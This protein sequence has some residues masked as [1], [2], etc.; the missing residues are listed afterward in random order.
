M[1]C[2]TFFRNS[3]ACACYWLV[4]IMQKKI[5]SNV[6]MAQIY[7]STSSISII[8][9]SLVK[10][11]IVKFKTKLASTT[12]TTT[13]VWICFSEVLILISFVDWL[14]YEIVFCLEMVLT[15]FLWLLLTTSCF[16]KF[17]LLEHNLFRLNPFFIWVFQFQNSNKK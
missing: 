15:E 10:T 2:L 1:R 12:T 13:T 4:R 6:V 5:P 8:V 17:E 7:I 16:K 3:V 9:M 14:I 11:T